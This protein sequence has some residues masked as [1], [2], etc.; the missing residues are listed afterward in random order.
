M[1]ILKFIFN[2]SLSQG[3]SCTL[4]KLSVVC[5]VGHNF[6]KTVAFVIY[7]FVSH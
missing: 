4:W 6:L 7:D 5:P 2:L 1:P 3:S